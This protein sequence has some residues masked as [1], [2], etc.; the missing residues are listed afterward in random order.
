[1]TARLIIPPAALAVSLEAARAAARLDGDQADAELRLAIGMY[2]EEA[3]HE[4]QRV[5]IT[6][7]WRVTLDGFSAAIRLPYAPLQSVAHVHFES[8]SGTLETLDPQ[9]YQVDNVSEPGYIVP[10]PDRAW[11]ATAARI[12]AVEVQ[13][14][15]G[16][17]PD[18]T[19]VPDAIKGFILAKVQEHFA[20]PGTPK[21]PYL[22]R[23]LDRYR[24]YL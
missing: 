2:T 8:T 3:E 17:G 5:L 20:A 16:Y 4:M 22:C 10:A 13:Y 23:L 14:T 24:V 6:Q 11:P 9:D 12:N 15:A 21:S 18:E 19:S 7:T 1:M